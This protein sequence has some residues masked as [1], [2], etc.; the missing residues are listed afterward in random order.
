[1]TKRLTRAGLLT[2]L[3]LIIF[4]LEAQLPPLVPI[5]GIKL[6]LANIGVL[7]TLYL[8]GPWYAAAVSIVRVV[9]N[10]VLFTGVSAM[11]YS[12]AGAVLALAVMIPLRACGRFGSVGV[13]V[14]GAVAH[15]AGQLAAAHFVTRTGAVW[16]YAPLL[17]AA[18]CAAGAVNGT[19]AALIV[20]GVR[21][22]PGG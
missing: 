13:S 3:A 1:M 6:G 8:L 15:I 4:V 12:M 10:G 2:A 19:A 16:A 20:R 11:L 21:R 9:L 17:T 22:T 14:G 7:I 18:A 5:P